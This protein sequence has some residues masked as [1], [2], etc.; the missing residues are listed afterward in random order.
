MTK[1]TFDTSRRH[2]VV[3][4]HWSGHRL[5]VVKR[6]LGQI[7]K[8][9]AGREFDL[10]LVCNGGGVKKTD[11]PQ[12]SDGVNFHLINRENQGYNIGAWDAGW[13]AAPSYDYYLFLQGECTLRRPNWLAAFES[14]HAQLSQNA[15]I[16]E[17]LMWENITWDELTE[18]TRRDFI[19]SYAG[20]NAENPIDTYRA[21]LKDMK[22]PEGEVATHLQSLVLFSNGTLLREMGGFPSRSIYKEAVACE[23]G[24]SR[25]AAAIGAEL[26]LLTPNKPFSFIVHPEWSKR[27]II[28]MRVR[29]RWYWFKGWV[30]SLLFNS[31]YGK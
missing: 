23:I 12:V 15:L 27:G 13:R 11:L 2:C 9:P 24:I 19:P 3:V 10:V 26:S 29:R 20:S 31:S 1:L 14:R 17:S 28:V 4:S 5:K 8:I 21:L 16:G 6:L 30:K 18:A 22:I 7:Q 25:K